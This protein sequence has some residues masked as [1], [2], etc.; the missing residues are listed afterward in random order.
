MF[1]GSASPG[2]VSVMTSSNGGHTPEQVA[3]LCVDRLMSVSE[4]APPEIAM[5]ARAFK[6]QMLAVVLHYVKMAAREDRESVVAKLEQAG[7]TDVA[8]QIR[9]L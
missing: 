2:V 4:S 8:Q 6:D 9:R 5:Q 1:V 3:E 7:A